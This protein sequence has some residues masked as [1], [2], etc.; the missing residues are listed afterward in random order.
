MSDVFCFLK[1]L[2]KKYRKTMITTWQHITQVMGTGLSM[3]TDQFLAQS[4]TLPLNQATNDSFQGAL[5]ILNQIPNFIWAF[6]ILVVGWVVALLVS[7]FV[8]GLLRKTDLDNRIAAGLMGRGTGEELP[9]VEG[10]I[11]SVAFWVI[12]MFVVVAVLQKLGLEIASEP[13]NALLR[14]LVGFLPR[15]LAAG[16]LLGLAWVVATVVRILTVR[17]LNAFRIDELVNRSED[18]VP[19]LNQMSLG[20]TIGNAL[21]WFVFLLF[22]IPI[23]DALELKQGLQP[24]QALITEIL[25]MLPNVLGAAI[26]FIVGWFTAN[27]VRRIVTNLLAATGINNLGSRFG[28]RAVAGGQ[29]LSGIIGTL[30]YVLILIPVAIAALNAL[31]I[32]AISIPAIA[33]L[34]R[35][36]DTLPAIFTAGVILTV[37]YFLARFVGEFVTSILTSIGFNN[38]FT[39]LGIPVPTPQQTVSLDGEPVQTRTTRTPSEIAGIVVLVGIMLFATVA[40]LDILRIPALTSLVQSILLVFGQILAGL[41]V[42]AIGLF[43][44]NLAFNIITS[45]GNAQALI[46]GQVARIAIIVLVSAMALQRIGIAPNIVNLAFGLLLGAIAVAIALAFGL[47]GRD[48]AGEQVREWLNSFKSRG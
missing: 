4:P 21:Y 3:G 32:D 7:S 26:I 42:F 44:A 13:L 8:K 14:Q 33:M 6:V 35:V 16:L 31:Q 45:S 23:L 29:P 34:Q 17:T 19:S 24:I 10:I 43:L 20:E 30:V 46:L 38:I 37:A 41:V 5:Q 22:L 28:L 12:M 36:L 11:G 2:T 39:A 15:L 27:V 9:K 40:A 25:A 1:H 47:G 18:T 48:V